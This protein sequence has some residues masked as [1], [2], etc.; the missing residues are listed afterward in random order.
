MRIL[1][2]FKSVDDSV[3]TGVYTSLSVSQPL[4]GGAG[5]VAGGREEEEEVDTSGLLSVASPVTYLL[6]AS[7]CTTIILPY[8]VSCCRRMLPWRLTSLKRSRYSL[9][10]I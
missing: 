10:L 9:W 7:L 3:L 1:I 6:E 2:N 8:M 4:V 5:G